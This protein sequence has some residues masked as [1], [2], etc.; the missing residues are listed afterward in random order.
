MYRHA[1]AHVCA[2]TQGNMKL[3]CLED[4]LDIGNDNTTIIT[5]TISSL[6]YNFKQTFFQYPFQTLW[7]KLFIVVA[8]K[9]ADI[10]NKYVDSI[11]DNVDDAAADDDN[12]DNNNDK[13]N[14]NENDNH[15]DNDKEYG[16]DNNTDN[17]NGLLLLT[18]CN[19]H[20]NSNN[21]DNENDNDKY[22]NNDK[23]YVKGIDTDSDL[24]PATLY[25]IRICISLWY[26]VSFHH[27]MYILIYLM[28]LLMR[29]GFRD[30]IPSTT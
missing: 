1:P 5:I 8:L 2:D 23:E 30:R 16:K 3:L 14:D 13:N 7:L 11:S 21:D 25:N 9:S 4:Y 6:V 19:L 22:N 26:L 10:C 20:P 15:N 17:D 18:M 24:L 27:H 29:R 28:V 12:D